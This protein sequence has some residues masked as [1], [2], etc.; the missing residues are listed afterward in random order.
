MLVFGRNRFAAQFRWMLVAAVVTGGACG[1]YAVEA[2]A[3]DKLPGGGSRVGLV[4]GT[5]GAAIIL[6][7]MLLWPRKRLLRSRT[8]PWFRTQTWMKAH[9]WLGLAV[10][11]VA[12][13]H[14]GFRF[15][16]TLTTWLM[17][18]FA[19][20]ILSGA[21]GLLL[22]QIIPRRILDLVPDE[23]PAAEIDRVMA[24]HTLGFVRRLDADRGE[25][26]GEPVAGAERLHEAF[27]A[28]VRPYLA[29]KA[30]PAVL[31]V[32]DRAGRWF[33]ELAAGLPPACRSRVAEL[34]Q[35]TALRRQLDT[36]A[37]LHWW[38]H[39]WVWVH[40]PISVALVGLLVAHIY[41]ALRYI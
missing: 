29:G 13:L 20:V 30:R 7:E 14:T 11:P 24:A 18:V 12:V 16:G 35:L 22:Q 26:G 1:W 2:V 36:Q 40:L 34:E 10:V 8:R 15:G 32:P 41:T 5:V 33:G 9:I 31:R 3:A 28:T 17:L 27:D 4:L 39:N 37:R 23:V 21:W 19:A 25:L 38:L 6:F